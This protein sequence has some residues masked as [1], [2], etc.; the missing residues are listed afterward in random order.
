VA[1]R[2]AIIEITTAAIDPAALIEALRGQEIDVTSDGDPLLLSVLDDGAP[3]FNER[4]FAV[5]EHV[6]DEACAP[7]IPEATGPGSFVLR[8]PA[9]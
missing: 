5:L 1:K 3:G 9:A 6:A 7:A 2:A 8:P 4:L